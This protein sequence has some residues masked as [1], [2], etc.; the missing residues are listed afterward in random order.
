M[1]KNQRCFDGVIST[2]GLHGGLQFGF[3][4]GGQVIVPVFLEFTGPNTDFNQSEHALYTCYSIISNTVMYTL[5]GFQYVVTE[6]RAIECSSLMIMHC[7]H[8]QQKINCKLFFAKD[9]FGCCG[10]H[11]T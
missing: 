2:L 5:N 6:G 10:D 7:L 9:A 3:K 1:H 8:C 4:D 11:E